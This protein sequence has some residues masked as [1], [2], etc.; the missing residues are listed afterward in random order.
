MYERETHDLR[1]RRME[2]NNMFNCNGLF[3]A[4]LMRSAKL[5]DARARLHKL[6]EEASETAAAII[7]FLGDSEINQKMTKQHDMIEEIVDCYI[8][9]TDVLV[10]HIL[11]A[12]SGTLDLLVMRKLEKFQSALDKLERGSN[13]EN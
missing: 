13:G 7:R 10:N 8:V 9:A 1:L 2:L 5:F 4:T 11:V 6:A 12:N 3:E